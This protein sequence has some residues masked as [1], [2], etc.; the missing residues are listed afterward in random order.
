MVIPQ[1]VT[2]CE[3]YIMKVRYEIGNKSVH[4]G[5]I[6]RCGRHVKLRCQEKFTLL[7]PNL[8]QISPCYLQISSK[9]HLATCKSRP[10][11]TL[12]PPNLTLLSKSSKS[13]LAISKSHPNLTL[14]P[15]NLIS[16]ANLPPTSYE[17]SLLLPAACLSVFKHKPMGTVQTQFH[18]WTLNS[19]HIYLQAQ[20][21]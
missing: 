14:L 3:N 16:K 18:T 21:K 2:S 9:A 6:I 12:V 11:L 13:Y 5:S 19:L 10:D 17:P 15:P 1:A 8:I 20:C 7:S 4:P